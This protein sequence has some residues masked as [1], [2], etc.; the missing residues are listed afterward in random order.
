M[1]PRPTP[2]TVRIRPSL[3]LA[4]A[5]FVTSCAGPATLSGLLVP[6]KLSQDQRLDQAVVYVES[7]NRRIDRNFPPRPGRVSFTFSGGA[8]DPTVGVAKI[9][10]WLEFHNADSV[11]HQP[12]SR[13]LA[14][15]F[16]GRS[17]RPGD[18]TPVRLR[19]KG[20]VQIFCQLHDGE[21]AELLV[22]DNGAWT[23]PDITGAFTL[24]T[25]PKGRYTVRAWHPRLG[26]QTIQVYVDETGPVSIELRY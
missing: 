3:I 20:L 26:E 17:V 1:E 7:K 18:A 10:A 15:P 23:R 14:A 4:L 5:L 11:F 2:L 12:F 13:S 21:S 19:A 22:L 16:E 9:G 6:K 8:L 24:P 25:L